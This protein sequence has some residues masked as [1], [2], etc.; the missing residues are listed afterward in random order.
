MLESDDLR[1]LAPLFHATY[2]PATPILLA[3][4]GMPEAEFSSEEG[5]QQG[6]G[7]AGLGFCAAMHPEIK[8]LDA[9]LAPSGGTAKF[10]QDDGYAAGAAAVVFPAVQRFARELQHLGLELQLSK[11]YCYSPT[12]SLEACP[13]RPPQFP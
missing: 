3:S 10:D 4:A 8:A 6:D 12:L 11:C 5:V 9:E 1:D 7:V 13:H 2:A